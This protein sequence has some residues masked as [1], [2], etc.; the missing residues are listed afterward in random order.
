MEVKDDT[1][2][3][4]VVIENKIYLSTD[5]VSLDLIAGGG[6]IAKLTQP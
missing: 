5:K 6:Y 2:G 3:N 4:A 1:S